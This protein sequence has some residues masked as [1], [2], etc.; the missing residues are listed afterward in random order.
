MPG[1]EQRPP[2]PPHGPPHR[3]VPQGLLPAA[4]HRPLQAA[5]Q[6]PAAHPTVARE[7]PIARVLVEGGSL[8]GCL[9]VASHFWLANHPALA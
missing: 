2:L 6:A 7:G 4:Q 1:Q 9:V 3:E 5:H 8:V